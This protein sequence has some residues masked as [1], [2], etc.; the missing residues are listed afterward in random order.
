MQNILDLIGQHVQLKKETGDEFSGPCIFCSDGQDRF[1]VWETS[2][3]YWCRK[4]DAQGDLYQFCKDA[5][6]MSHNDIL[7]AL[8]RG[9]ER[10][11]LQVI[12]KPIMT[13]RK[14]VEAKIERSVWSGRAE[15][16]AVWCHKQLIKSPALL[17]WLERER[18]IN[19][20]TVDYWQLG[21]NPQKQFS[22]PVLWGFAEGNKIFL[23]CGLV[24]PHRRQNGM[25]TGINVRRF[26]PGDQLPAAL[27][28]IERQAEN[29]SPYARVR[30]TIS[31]PWALSD[32]PDAPRIVVESELDALLIWQELDPFAVPVAILTASAKPSADEIGTDAPVLFSLDMDEAGKKHFARWKQEHK[33]LAFPPIRG[34]DITDMHRS[35]VALVQWFKIGLKRNGLLSPDHLNPYAH[36]TLMTGPDWS[37][38]EGV[39]D[40]V[41]QTCIDPDVSPVTRW[42]SVCGDKG[43]M[44]AAAKDYRALFGGSHDAI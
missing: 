33:A 24:I 7:T 32:R 31:K 6:S 19:R 29:E 30:G 16:S 4:C 42:Q 17:D 9:S 2:Q 3:R 23:P 8:G 12:S 25:I 14:P 21:F 20:S 15:R 34:K 39:P 26:K 13:P 10:S 44:L 41:Y 5:L 37:H 35:G 28:S 38:S 18:G 1:R 22:D 43:A 40:Q 27:D 11:D 36:F